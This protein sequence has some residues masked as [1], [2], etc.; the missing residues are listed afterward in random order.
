[1]FLGLPNP[2]PDP[3][4]RGRIRSFH[5]PAKIG[6][7]TLI[8][9]CDSFLLLSLKN[10]VNVPLK[11]NNQKKCLNKFSVG[12]LKVSDENGRIRIRIH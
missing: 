8:P 3:L 10:D 11:S 1:M 7:K 4:V 5:Q 9:T 2:D 12:I 6:R